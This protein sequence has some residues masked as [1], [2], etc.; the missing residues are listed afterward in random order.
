MVVYPGGYPVF[1]TY[2]RVAWFVSDSSRIG[3]YESQF[4]CPDRTHVPPNA[5]SPEWMFVRT[6]VPRTYVPPTQLSERSLTY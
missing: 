3:M 5:R 2:V 1:R 4:V 6:H